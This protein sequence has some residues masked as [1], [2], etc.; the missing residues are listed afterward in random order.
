MRK[1]LPAAS[2]AVLL[3]SSPT[4][5]FFQH[6]EAEKFAEAYNEYAVSRGVLSAMTS[7][8]VRRANGD[9]FFYRLSTD[10]M[11]IFGVARDHV[12]L[13][14]LTIVSHCPPDRTGEMGGQ[15]FLVS[16]FIADLCS[17]APAEV[18]EMKAT[19]RK[20]FMKWDWRHELPDANI[21]LGTACHLLIR[22]SVIG[23][24]TVEV[25]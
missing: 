2:V 23:M 22:F 12:H 8:V 5:A 13:D 24:L 21:R 10:C 3:A 7:D 25:T 19:Y 17:A 20:L 11:G 6:Y 14:S 1:F 9:S 4:Q 15:V 18:A 16:E